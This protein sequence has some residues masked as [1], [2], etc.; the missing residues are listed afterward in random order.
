VHE[1]HRFASRSEAEDEDDPRQDYI[2]A[3]DTGRV[4]FPEMERNVPRG[5]E[6]A[7]T[8]DAAQ[9]DWGRDVM[10]DVTRVLRPQRQRAQDDGL[11][12][13]TERLETPGSQAPPQEIEQ[14]DALGYGDGQ[15]TIR[16]LAGTGRDPFNSYMR[17]AQRR[18]R[19]E[20][21]YD[22]AQQYERAI[23]RQ[24]RNPLGHMGRGLALFGAGERA[25]AADEL[26][27]AV[28]LFPDLSRVQV[29]VPDLLGRQ[30]FKR[31]ARELGITDDSLLK[32]LTDKP[33]DQ[34]D[35][36]ETFLATFMLRHAGEEERTRAYAEVLQETAEAQNDP[37]MKRYAERL[38]QRY[39]E[40][41]EA[42][43]EE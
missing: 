39:D 19:G 2:T 41:G 30:T 42:E 43:Q 36:R 40:A 6:Q 31:R 5:P 7:Q 22:A 9:A 23:A 18:L 3:E 8:E 13:P 35:L 32:S 20:Q 34:R 21:Y 33:A 4:R 14:T 24:R 29:D 25:S 12:Q 28:G 10:L 37:R 11:F 38:L 27:R 17:T 15:V 16:S 1:L 26:Q